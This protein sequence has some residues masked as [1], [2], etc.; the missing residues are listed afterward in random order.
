M[1]QRARVAD[2]SG[3]TLIEVLVVILIIGVL[4]AIALPTFLGQRE[5]AIDSEAKAAVRN[6]VSQVELCL[7]QVGT[8]D[9]ATCESDANVTIALD[10]ATAGGTATVTGLGSYVLT[11]VSVTGN[12]FTIEKAAGATS[13]SCT[14]AGA[15]NGGCR[16]AQW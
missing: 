4:A 14:S 3:F 8:A 10:A 12:A 11:A 5:K 2:E 16:G 7:A 1:L 13:R 15:S 9:P 6:A